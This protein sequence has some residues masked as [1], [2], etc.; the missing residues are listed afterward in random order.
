MRFDDSYFHSNGKFLAIQA[1]RIFE[2]FS[3]LIWA[4]VFSHIEALLVGLGVERNL[5]LSS[6]HHC[7]REIIVTHG[8][9]QFAAKL[10]FQII[11]QNIIKE[12]NQILLKIF[13]ER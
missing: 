6:A 3:A 8:K 9:F 13:I 12:K 11:N 10:K 7:A 4:S 5:M 1:L 2:I